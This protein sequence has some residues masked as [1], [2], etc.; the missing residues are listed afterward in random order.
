MALLD[1]HAAIVTGGG[2][3]IGQATCVRMAEEGATVAVLDVNG[4][5]AE[6]TAK[7]VGGRGYQVDV[8][9]AD[10]VQRT[11]AAAARALGGLSI[12]FNNAGVGTFGAIE[13]HDLAE[14]DRVVR[15]SLYGVFH[16]LRAAAP[17]MLEGGDGRI[18]NT[19][20]IS[21][22]RP[23]AGEAPY[24]SAKAGIVALTASAALELAPRVRVNAVSPGLVHS[25]LTEPMFQDLTDHVDHVVG[26]T[27]VGRA[28]EPVDI[29]DVVVFLCSDLARFVTG[30]NIVV[31]GGLTLHTSGVDGIFDRV[32]P[33][34]E[35]GRSNPAS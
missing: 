6:A 2:S 7:D 8:T 34:L 15:V 11:V 13:T 27:P 23:A 30:Q 4:D 22:V 29:A 9:D 20:S 1:G 24:S 3:G 14:W 16:G 32:R 33:L 12:M 10:Q 26:T 5:A 18:V 17:I 25:A 19:A 31:D 35:Q 21:G 28:G